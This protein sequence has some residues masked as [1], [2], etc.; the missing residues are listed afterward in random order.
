MKILNA[1]FIALTILLSMLIFS[2]SSQNGEESAGLSEKITYVVIDILYDDYDRFSEEKQLEIK[3]IIHPIVRKTAHFG[4]YGL[5]A[6]LILSTIATGIAAYKKGCFVSIWSKRWFVFAV[7]TQ[8]IT[9]IY[10]STDEF[11]QGF[12]DGRGP[13]VKDVLIDSLGGFTAIIVYSVIV[14]FAIMWYNSRID[15]AKK[16]RIK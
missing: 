5:L 12:V 3:E 6:T 4:E 16:G 11:H 1:I 8:V 15:F 2:F 9:S 7:I 10:A 13:S 14:Y